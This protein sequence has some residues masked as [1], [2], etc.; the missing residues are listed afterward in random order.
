[1]SKCDD[2]WAYFETASFLSLSEDY[3]IPDLNYNT[4]AQ[5]YF[6]PSEIK[7][8][9]DISQIHYLSSLHSSRDIN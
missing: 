9:R 8:L 2:L 6:C 7:Q 1:M 3:L 4:N 5:S